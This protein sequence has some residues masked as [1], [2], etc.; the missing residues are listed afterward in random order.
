M[1]KMAEVGEERVAEKTKENKDH[2]GR[3]I[4][5]MNTIPLL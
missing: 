4:V 3:D 1:N 2:F 5:L